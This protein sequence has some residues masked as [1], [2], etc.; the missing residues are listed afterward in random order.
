MLHRTYKST[1]SHDINFHL[2]LCY[3]IYVDK[4]CFSPLLWYVALFCNLLIVMAAALLSAPYNH[5]EGEVSRTF[6]SSTFL[7]MRGSG[8]IFHHKSVKNKVVFITAKEKDSMFHQ[9]R[10]RRLKK[11]PFQ[12][13]T[14]IKIKE[15]HSGYLALKHEKSE[16][17]NKFQTT[18]RNTYQDI[19][20]VTV[21]VIF[22]QIPFVS[23]FE[24]HYSDTWDFAQNVNYGFYTKRVSE[25]DRYRLTI[26]CAS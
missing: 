7:W 26:C 15:I 19:F 2:L 21:F 3:T 1:H 22:M 23:I 14:I 13:K 4:H 24:L 17:S 11:K 9:Y 16:F 20:Y 5:Q 25:T 10:T 18:F 6:P 8:K 12:C